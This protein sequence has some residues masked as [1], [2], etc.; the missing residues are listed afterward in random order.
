MIAAC[1]L[2]DAQRDG[3]RVA[4]LANR[5]GRREPAERQHHWNG[6]IGGDIAAPLPARA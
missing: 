2:A 4:A 5:P 3:R 6:C 1:G